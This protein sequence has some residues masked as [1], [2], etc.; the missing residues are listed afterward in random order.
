MI[1]SNR[2]RFPVTLVVLVMA[3]TIVL[4]SNNAQ[5]QDILLNDDFESG[6]GNWTATDNAGLYTGGTYATSGSNAGRMTD[7]M[8]TLTTPLLLD[9]LGYTDVNI[10]FN[11]KW[12]TA[13]GTR[14]LYTYF[15]S[16]N[17]ASW[18]ELG[19]F[20]YS[21]NY[22]YTLTEGLV[23]GG[24]DGSSFTDESLFRFS[25]YDSGGPHVYVDD[26]VITGSPEF[27]APAVPEPTSVA[28]WALLGL[29]MVG[30]YRKRRPQ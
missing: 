23:T 15:S 27:V 28:L 2:I 24:Y 20:T 1:N 21:E 12:N 17:G 4:S 10:D 13:S 22:D 3:C 19:R 30:I 18:D 26:V 14:R 11:I 16:D 8:L 29:G 5:A 7:G 6:L 9:T 25:F